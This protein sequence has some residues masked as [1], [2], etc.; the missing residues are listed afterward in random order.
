MHF[1]ATI[2]ALAIGLGAFA[3][4]FAI[5]PEHILSGY[6]GLFIGK[7]TDHVERMIDALSANGFNSID[8]KLQDGRRTYDIDG[9]KAKLKGLIDRAHVKGLAFNVYL[10]PV[11]G[12]GGR[13]PEWDEH[14]ALPCP[15][16][17]QGCAIPNA[18]L[19]TESKV[20][21]RLFFHGL[22]Y[23][24]LQSELGFDSLRFDIETISLA[25]SYD[26]A[27]WR[28]YVANR[29]ELDAS[30]PVAQRRA[31]LDAK[32]LA[33]DYEA[34]FLKNVTTAVA[35]FV[36]ALRERSPKIVLGYMPAD[37]HPLSVC[38]D[39]TLAT[40][41]VPAILDA[42]DLYNGGG[43]ASSVKERAEA[44]K[45]RHPMN[46]FVAWIRPNTYAVGTIASAAYHTAAN[47]DGYSMWS[48]M[49]LDDAI[50]VKPKSMALPK[51]VTGTDY[52]REY[53]RANAA[54]RKDIAEGTLSTPM[55]IAPIKIRPLVA[56]LK[57]DAIDFP[58][59]GPEGDGTGDD[60]AV[61]LRNAQTIYIYA[62]IGQ[63]IR[64]TIEHLAG[65]KRPLALQYAL[66]G[67]KCG[68]LRNEAVSPGGDE[69]FAV[70]APE[71][72]LYALR[73][74]GGEDGQ[75]WYSIKVHAPLHWTVDARRGTYLFRPQT[76]FV[77]GA[78]CGNRTLH[79]VSTP[80]EA[81]RLFLNDKLE[82]DVVRT[83]ISD[84]DLPDGIVKVS[85]RESLATKYGENFNITFPEGEAGWVY[86]IK[87][88]RLR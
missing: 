81:Y 62:K 53:G 66:L 17:A 44:A 29:R 78:D 65:S 63:E 50:A 8:V 6:T 79:V 60:A 80:A 24:E 45:K 11:P 55:R 52:L 47:V 69:T 31:A 23:A 73:I 87:E 14:A 83:P 58:A 22:R 30:M 43:Y 26:D 40:N 27:T 41:D 84:F 68:L 67:E 18:F 37:Y 57:W 46:R 48:L 77:P 56:P 39:D 75:A 71:T 54:I 15:V 25:V 5:P 85:F 2:L 86:P 42:W 16:D 3:N 36:G 21:K 88:R 7:N 76:V 49:M 32:G 72:G 33:K 28:G 64:V 20:W 35:D 82:R 19:L 74:T 1:K 70:W 51:G 34:S 10:Y 4:V 61:I 59:I 38:F 13:K 12:D 9:R